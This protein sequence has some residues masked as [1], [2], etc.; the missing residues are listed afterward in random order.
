VRIALISSAAFCSRL[1]SFPPKRRPEREQKGGF[2]RIKKM[3][4][5]SAGAKPCRNGIPRGIL[6]LQRAERLRLTAAGRTVFCPARRKSPARE[7]I[8]AGRSVLTNCTKE[9][10]DWSH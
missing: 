8:L 2:G 7:G 6:L 4:A 5:T 10:P 1:Q 3:K 9:R